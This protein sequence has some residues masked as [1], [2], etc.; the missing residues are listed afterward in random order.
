MFGSTTSNYGK[1]NS[2][3]RGLA[4]MCS[5]MTVVAAVNGTERKSKSERVKEYKGCTFGRV[6]EAGGGGEPEGTATGIG[7]LFGR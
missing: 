5:Y 6:L 3:E 1:S 4:L 2:W 7:V